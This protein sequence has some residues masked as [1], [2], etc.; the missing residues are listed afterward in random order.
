[1]NEKNESKNPQA[2]G[3]P[4][5]LFE[6]AKAIVD[7]ILAG[8]CVQSE[9]LP[10]LRSHGRILA[11]T[12]ISR[13]DLPPFNKSAM[14]GYAV[15]DGEERDEY[16][17]LEHVLAGKVPSKRLEPGTASKVMTGAPV[18]EGTGRVIIVEDTDRGD[19]LVRVFTHRADANI[20]W[21]GEDVRVG[22]RLP[23]NGTMLGALS[24]ANLVACGISEVRVA[25]PIRV[26][27][28]TTGDEIVDSVEDIV[29][30]KIMDSNGPMLEGLALKH[31]LD[32]VT[33]R[34]VE[35]DRTILA[36]AIGD[37]SARADITILSGGVSAGDSDFVPQA[38]TDAGFAIHFDRVAMKPGKP[39]TFAS[40]DDRVAFGLPGN[41][42]SVFV[43]FHLFVLRAT[44][45]LSGV[46]PTER[47]FHVRLRNDIKRKSAE[48][49]ALVPGAIGSDGYA[50]PIA[51]HGSAHLLALSEAD[52]FL[53]IPKGVN[54]I[55]AGDDILFY[56]VMLEGV[57]SST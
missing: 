43:G 41:P 4:M 56:P 36:E 52:G 2:S 53:Q 27:I 12:P 19:E 16:R 39:L 14:D 22:Q 35:D 13:L 46:S 33:R 23:G 1:M 18:P 51:Y 20:C 50:E 40:K 42:V 21:K 29:P 17:V 38:L 34:I 28:L 37:A 15:M 6:E 26:A 49:I 10:V 45:Q 5:V 11:E 48:R 44:V 25:R 31:H 9:T 55:H 24:V 8:R 30:G 3:R 7:N 54:Q 47:S 32:V 57:R